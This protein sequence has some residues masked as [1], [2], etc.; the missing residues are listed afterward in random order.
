ME[1]KSIIA[2]ITSNTLNTKYL[3]GQ[4]FNIYSPTPSALMVRI[5]IT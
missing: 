1:L 4:Q 5:H 2:C 3:T